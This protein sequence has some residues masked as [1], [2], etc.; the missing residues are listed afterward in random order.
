MMNFISFGSIY[1]FF[2]DKEKSILSLIIFFPI[3]L[4][5]DM[6]HSR[7]AVSMSLGLLFFD[8]FYKKHYLKSL[9]FF[10]IAMMFHRTAL[11]LIVIPPIIFLTKYLQ[12]TWNKMFYV[13]M[14]L[15]FTVILSIRFD[16]ISVL[17]SPLNNNLTSKLYFK[18]SSYLQNNRWLS[19][20]CPSS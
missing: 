18:M 16:L 20:M 5:Y 6:H 14:L 1:L 15:I 11:I 2:K 19:K 13:S 10:A 4:Q 9:L 8:S 12:F 3:L 7:S 17:I